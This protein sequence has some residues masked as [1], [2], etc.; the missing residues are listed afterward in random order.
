MGSTNT[1]LVFS[2]FANIDAK[3][4]SQ[5][6]DD[7]LPALQSLG[8]SPVLVSSPCGE[9]RKDI[10]H[11]RAPSAA[12]SGMRFELRYLRRRNRF[13]KFAL[14]P[15]LV[16]VLPFYLLEKAIINLESEWSWFPFAFLRGISLCRKYRPEL[17]YSTGGPAS[18]HVAAGLT[19]RIA[20]LPWIA[21]LQD[22]IV[23]KDWTRSKASLRI[24]SRIERF[25]FENA[26]TVVFMTEGTTERAVARTGMDPEK[27]CVIYPGAPPIGGA[28]TSWIKGQF[29]RFAHFGS[30][31]GSRNVGTM[32]EALDAVISREPALA[33]VVRFDLYGTMD[34]LSRRMVA[35]FKHPGIVT[36]FGKVSRPDA[37]RAMMKSDVL[38]VIQN[39]DDLS[40]ETIPSKV[41]EYLQVNRPVL[42]LVY[43]N[44]SL[45][46]MLTSLGHFAAE[47]DNPIE[48]AERIMKI[49]VLWKKE[50]LNPSEPRPSPYTVK[51]AT[52]QLLT[53][54]RKVQSGI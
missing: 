22:P 21:E 44:P 37:H 6:I 43:R 45:T 49:L 27:A 33:G 17:I 28:H 35:D 2:Y 48:A 7:R 40:Y 36:D 47:A 10:P 26:S 34:K 5:H 9:R 8:K 1:W 24:A 51:A 11:F 39:R 12:P 30:L 18:A 15:A 41:Y 20:K 19:A 50:E 38:V 32:L 25:I 4:S 53:L 23:F 31:G 13:L 46:R 54:S 29:C 52:E 3:A 42:G 16:L 14:L